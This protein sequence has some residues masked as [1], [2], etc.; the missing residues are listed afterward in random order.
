VDFMELERA[1]LDDRHT[2]SEAFHDTLEKRR[3]AGAGEDE[4]AFRATIR[5][6]Y[7]AQLGEKLRKHLNLIE[8]DLIRMVRK[9]EIKIPL[10]KIEIGRFFEVDVSPIWPKHPGQRRLP[11]LSRT[12]Q[13][14]RRELT[15][16]TLYFFFQTSANHRKFLYVVIVLCKRKLIINLHSS[17]ESAYL[18]EI[19]NRA[20]G[21]VVFGEFNYICP[22]QLSYC[23]QPRKK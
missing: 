2:P 11:A 19:A 1:D 8:D 6:D 12:K 16:R 4:A 14:Y 10:H 3:R 18:H 5:I 23:K 21:A 22:S 15:Q 13:H 7:P 9:K 17:L 20:T